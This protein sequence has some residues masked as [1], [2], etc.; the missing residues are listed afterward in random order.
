MHKEFHAVTR[1]VVVWC[2]PMD[3]NLKSYTGREEHFGTHD[4][5]DSETRKRASY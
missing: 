3:L 2:I 5:R 4:G 1:L